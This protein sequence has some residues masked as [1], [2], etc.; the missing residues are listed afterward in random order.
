MHAPALLPRI[1]RT[2][3]L[4]LTLGLAANGV[5]QAHVHEHGAVKL[6][7]A[8]EPGR[9]SVQRES[10]LD[11]LIGFEHAPRTDAERK[12]VEAMVARLK[13]ADGLFKIDP[14]A[15]C[16]VAAVDLVS[17]PL[18]LG[19]PE[20]GGVEDG[21]GDLDGDFTFNCK[22]STR[23]AFIELG[24]FSAFSGMQRLDVQ[25]AAPKGQA[26]QTLKRPATR[27]DLPR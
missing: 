19:K 10:P 20:P 4:A 27:L 24:L 8:V 3:G 2:L 14:A 7:V 1:T 12:K 16:T 26:K 18:K 13:A 15:G 17:A 21:H 25:I 9:I 23:A 11:N 6:D 5:V 22:E